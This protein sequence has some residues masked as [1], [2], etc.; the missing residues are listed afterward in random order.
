MPDWRREL[1]ARLAA[2]PLTGADETEVVEELAQH[3]DEE[4]AELVPQ[5][6]ADE[7]ERRLLALLEEPSLRDLVRARRAARPPGPIAE[8][9][10]SLT[11]ALYRVA[12]D[13]RYAARRSRKHLA[14]TTVA[15]LSL[16][17]GIGANT[18][19][20][21]LVDAVMLRRPP[22]PHREQIAELYQRQ[23]SFPY[24]PLSYPD[25]V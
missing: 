3:L 20:F 6:G 21:S 11:G 8:T 7:A 16:A 17:I 12:A 25:Y 5:I 23:R 14:F 19:I 2:L 15:V 4:Y 13:L 22:V 9:P 18:A 1:R 10:R 24:A